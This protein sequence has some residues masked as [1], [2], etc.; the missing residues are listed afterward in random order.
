MALY[1]VESF[2]ITTLGDGVSTT[3]TVDLY[4]DIAA[5]TILPKNPRVIV[6]T[7]SN[8]GI[9]TSAT[10]V[11]SAVDVVFATPPSA[12]FQFNINITLGF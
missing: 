7:S 6:S 10:L 2:A 11:G 8:G 12:N 1:R 5:V 4:E 9:I 3:I